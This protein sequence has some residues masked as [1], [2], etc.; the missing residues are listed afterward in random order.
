MSKIKLVVIP[1]WL[2]LI[3]KELGIANADL[4]NWEKLSGIV[5]SRD[6]LIYRLAQ[7]NQRE[8]LQRVV[9]TADCA[10]DFDSIG[11]QL[12]LEERAAT[13]NISLETLIFGATCN[14][15]GELQ[16]R[17]E[18]IDQNTMGLFLCTPASNKQEQ[19]FKTD[20]RSLVL[21]IAQLLHGFMSTQRLAKKVS[22]QH[23][24]N[25]V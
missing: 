17:V 23:A 10:D 9:G 3:M 4:A 1:V 6:L 8:I 25:L 13:A 12:T 7:F 15:Q 16:A 20:P 18:M 21:E 11:E 5:S 14:Q 24:I 19:E 2:N 22:F